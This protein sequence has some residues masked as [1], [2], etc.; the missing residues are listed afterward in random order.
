M[1]RK[2]NPYKPN[3]KTRDAIEF[4]EWLNKEGYREY[5]Y[6]DR[7]IAPQ[8]NNNVYDTKQLYEMFKNK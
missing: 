4:A 5:D 2:L 3:A 1:N 7:W 6:C 8:N